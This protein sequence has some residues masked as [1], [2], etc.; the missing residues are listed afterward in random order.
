MSSPR[1]RCDFFYRTGGCRHGEDCA[2]VHERFQTSDT[3]V[4]PN[5]VPFPVKLGPDV[6]AAYLSNALEDLFLFCDRFGR[7][8]AAGL[9]V[10]HNHLFGN[11]YV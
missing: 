1:A 4:V 3:L 9:A 10:N 8:C 5:A 6:M 2:R 11:F 7:I